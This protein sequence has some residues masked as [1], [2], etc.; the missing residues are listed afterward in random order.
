MRDTLII[1]DV[2]QG[3]PE[4]QAVRAGV[5]TASD[6]DKL[7]TPARLGRSGQLETYIMGKAAEAY[8]GHAADSYQSPWM[9]WGLQYEDEARRYYEMMTGRAT[10]RPGFIFLNEGRMVGGSPDAFMPD[11]ETGLEIKC[12]SPAVHTRYLL[13]GVLPVEYLCQV[14]GLMYVTGCPRWDFMSYHPELPQF[15][16]TVEAD[17]K[18]QEAIDAIMAEATG[19]LR[20]TIKRLREV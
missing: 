12:P 7:I 2:E 10:T 11:L 3:T 13:D 1:V 5:I 16:I 15:I 19:M 14:Q 6:F 17:T 4:W 20:H 8:M 18:F 9:A